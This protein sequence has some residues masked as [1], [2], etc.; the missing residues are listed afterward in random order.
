MQPGACFSHATLMRVDGDKRATTS[1]SVAAVCVFLALIAMV[2]EGTIT[3]TR[4]KTD[5]MMS[6]GMSWLK[7]T[8]KLALIKLRLIAC[9]SALECVS[10]VLYQCF[11]W[12]FQQ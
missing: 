2:F 11:A 8:F 4:V 9:Q 3:H 12:K 5:K 7:I 6:D 10:T 1:I